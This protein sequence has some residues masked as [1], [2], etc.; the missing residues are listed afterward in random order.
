MPYELIF[1]KQS[2]TKCCDEIDEIASEASTVASSESEEINPLCL[3][4]FDVNNLELNTTTRILPQTLVPT[5][6]AWVE[7]DIANMSSFG[8]ITHNGDTLT[9]SPD[10]RTENGILKVYDQST[11]PNSVKTL[12]RDGVQYHEGSVLTGL[13]LLYEIFINNDKLIIKQQFKSIGGG[14]DYDSLKTKFTRDYQC[15][16]QLTIPG[17]VKTPGDPSELTRVPIPNEIT[18]PAVCD[19]NNLAVRSVY[20]NEIQSTDNVGDLGYLSFLNFATPRE[21]VVAYNLVPDTLYTD[22]S[23]VMISGL[24][25]TDDYANLPTEIVFLTEGNSTTPLIKF[26]KNGTNLEING[27]PVIS[28]TEV[29]ANRSISNNIPYLLTET[30]FIINGTTI[31]IN[32]DWTNKL[33]LYVTFFFTNRAYIGSSYGNSTFGFTNTE[34]ADELDGVNCKYYWLENPV[35]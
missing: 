2:L 22:T 11:M 17:I 18:V 21:T 25:F 3:V 14:G 26:V 5:F 33:K 6:Q 27:T 19:P 32:I 8:M 15:G 20:E 13:Y 1:N 7:I 16:D 28:S 24:H 31:N 12:I 29:D 30:K 35:A 9:F 34:L 23:N 10:I 4:P